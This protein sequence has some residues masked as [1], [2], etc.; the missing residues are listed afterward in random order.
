M[1]PFPAD[2]PL[3]DFASYCAAWGRLH[4]G[5][6]PATGSAWV[7]WWLRVQYRLARPLAAAGVS[8]SL[9]TAASAVLAA[10]SVGSAAAGGRWPLVAAGLVVLSGVGDGR[11]GAVAILSDRVTA[12]GYVL[13][14]VVDRV[15]ERL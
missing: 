5:Y 10:G 12:W 13:D 11:D 3:P 15:S 14:S 9:L 2:R 7:Q 4:A 1:R 6:D 8:P